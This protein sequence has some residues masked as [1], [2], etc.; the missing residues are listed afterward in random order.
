ML[1][2]VLFYCPVPSRFVSVAL[3]LNGVCLC[4]RV[5]TRSHTHIGRD[6][7]GDTRVI[8]V[9]LTNSENN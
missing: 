9:K 8:L 1:L 4:V 3:L 6:E 2:F 7:L 5:E